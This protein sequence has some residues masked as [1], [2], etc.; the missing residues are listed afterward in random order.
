MEIGTILSLQIFH[1]DTLIVKFI[2]K[3]FLKKA[4]KVCVFEKLRDGKMTNAEAAVSLIAL[5]ACIIEF[6]HV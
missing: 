6:R 2:S 1:L 5:P 4:R 3:H